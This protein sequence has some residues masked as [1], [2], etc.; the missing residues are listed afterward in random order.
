APAA[1]G[2]GPP[3]PAV[4]RIGEVAANPAAGPGGGPPPPP[5]AP[6]PG[7]PASAGRGLPRAA[8]GRRRAGG[9]GR[10]PDTLPLRRHRGQRHVA[11]TGLRWH[12]AAG[13]RA[14]GAALAD[15]ATT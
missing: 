14:V 10:P 4:G 2:G 12:P 8:G 15:G 9:G 11:G 1:P 13:D 5:L 6:R 7:A 3:K